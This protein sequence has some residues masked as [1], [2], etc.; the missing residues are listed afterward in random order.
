MRLTESLMK[1]LLRFFRSETSS[2]TYLEGLNDELKP[3]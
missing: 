3:I 1:I 2:S